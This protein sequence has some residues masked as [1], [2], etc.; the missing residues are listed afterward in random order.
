MLPVVQRELLV[1]SRS[2]GLIWSRWLAAFAG[3]LL[4]I[5]LLMTS[6][7][8]SQPQALMS[9]LFGA[10]AVGLGCYAV[11]AGVLHTADALS[12]ERREETLGLLFL[13][14]LRSIDV[15]IGKLLAS[16]MVGVQGFLAVLPILALPMLFGGTSGDEFWRMSLALLSVLAGSLC[17]GLMISGFCTRHQTAVGM[18]LLATLGRVIV[19]F[20]VEMGRRARIEGKFPPDD[21]GFGWGSPLASLGGSL[22]KSFKTVGGANLY[23]WSIWLEWG[24]ALVSL[25]VCAWWTSRSIRTANPMRENNVEGERWAWV[26]RAGAEW[27]WRR[28]T[29]RV[30]MVRSPYYWLHRAFRQ[31]PGWFGIAWW[32]VWAVGC[33]MSIL[34][35]SQQFSILALVVLHQL[36]KGGLALVASQGIAEDRRSG[37]LELLIVSGVSPETIASGHHRAVGQQFQ[38][39]LWSLVGLQVVCGVLYLV[40]LMP[41][42]GGGLPN[43]FQFNMPIILGMGIWL[44]FRDHDALIACSMREALRLSDPQRAFRNA[45]LRVMWPGWLVMGMINILGIGG[46][47]LNGMMVGVV[48]LVVGLWWA[49]RIQRRS[50]VDIEYGFMAYAAGLPFDS[51]EWSL[52]DDFRRAANA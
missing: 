21:H 12:R 8:L 4:Y 46:A 29:G 47:A 41:G 18:T 50:R 44:L 27:Y 5:V 26:R 43:S 32:S 10:I 25:I 17:L 9:T 51:D 22:D 52:R 1:A 38:V 39:P 40:P 45:W 6:V 13:T 49:K 28:T 19:C 36:Y 20:L 35:Q 30:W 14:E 31:R 34:Q 23:W 11:L 7:A 24:L 37:A 48:W 2:R 3:T 16:S 33:A 15:I 42:P